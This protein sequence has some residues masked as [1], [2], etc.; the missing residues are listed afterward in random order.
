MMNVHGR[1]QEK[2]DEAVCLLL[3]CLVQ[4][5]HVFRTFRDF[6]IKVLDFQ[7]HAAIVLILQVALEQHIPLRP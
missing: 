6:I 4:M 7:S 5:I 1:A 2:M 3:L